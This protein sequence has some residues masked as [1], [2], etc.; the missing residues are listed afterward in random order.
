MVFFWQFSENSKI[1][2]SS[3]AVSFIETFLA[4][5][6]SEE[7]KQ[8]KLSTKESHHCFGEEIFRWKLYM[9]MSYFRMTSSGL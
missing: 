8:Q 4:W 6:T 9:V 1:F 2:L 7:P 5:T 3:F